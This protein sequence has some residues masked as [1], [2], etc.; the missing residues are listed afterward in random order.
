M[1]SK[2]L[3]K[4]H[5][6]ISENVDGDFVILK[7]KAD[8]LIELTERYWSLTGS[9]P[10]EVNQE[11]AQ[12]R[13]YVNVL[14]RILNRYKGM[15]DYEFHMKVLERRLNQMIENKQDSINRV[16]N[17]LNNTRNKRQRFDTINTKNKRQ[18]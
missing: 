6:K 7:N 11:V 2:L 1:K 18:R 15:I 5:Q 10:E 3:S 16:A 14:F 12:M 9:T 13:N 8:T 4:F 17:M